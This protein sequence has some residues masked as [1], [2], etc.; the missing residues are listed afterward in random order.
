MTEVK[1]SKNYRPKVSVVVLGRGV[2]IHD[3]KLS[4]RYGAGSEQ[5]RQSILEE[6]KNSKGRQIKPTRL[7]ETAVLKTPEKGIF[8]PEEHPIFNKEADPN[9]IDSRYAGANAN[10]IAA[11]DVVGGIIDEN[12]K[13]LVGVLWAAGRTPDML[14]YAPEGLTQGEVLARKFI[15]HVGIKVMGKNIQMV[16]EPE[17]VNT[18]DDLICSL[19]WAEAQ[20]SDEIII[21]TV[22][23]HMKRSK[24]M[25]EEVLGEMR[26]EGL[27]I[28]KMDYV[29]SE[30]RLIQRNPRYLSLVEKARD[31]LAYHATSAR[32][33]S[34]M[35]QRK[36]GTYRSQWQDGGN[37]IREYSKLV[38]VM[39]PE[40][41][42]LRAM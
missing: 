24:D 21:V 25:A 35:V 18:W 29:I 22:K 7:I 10:V 32:E 3:K 15:N 20:N 19:K 30:E 16:F 42:Q 1:E 40:E 37:K 39:T 13:E 38:L 6:I 11:V 5:D 9:A 26:A 17:N 8:G 14:S 12:K 2:G 27:K 4:L 33:H 36:I 28:P 23:P 34:G 31:S 41:V